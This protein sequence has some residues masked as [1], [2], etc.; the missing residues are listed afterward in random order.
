MV[1]SRAAG[2]AARQGP[3]AARDRPEGGQADPRRQR[4]R[5]PDEDGVDTHE[6]N[7][8]GT[9]C[10]RQRNSRAP[11]PRGGTRITPCAGGV[12]A[13]G[14]PGEGLGGDRAG[15]RTGEGRREDPEETVMSTSDPSSDAAAVNPAWQ[16]FRIR[17]EQ[18]LSA[19]HGVLAQVALHWI[20]P[21]ADPQT[22]PGVPGQWQ[23]TADRL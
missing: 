21:G 5:I 11:A 12:D 9:G 23:L 2:R 3:G 7:D 13:G 10:D 4:R 15:R 16:E 8:T 17:R 14:A 22:V 18:G 6:E 20:E 1:R 19:P